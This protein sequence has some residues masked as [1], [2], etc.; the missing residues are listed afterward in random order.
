MNQVQLP[1]AAVIENPR[2]YPSGAIESLRRL[3]RS[4]AAPEPDPR[5]ENF[6]QIDGDEEVYYIYVSP[7]SGNVVLLAN[8][9]LRTQEECAAFEACLT[10]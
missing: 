2:E 9:S 4:G 3:L 5:R 10:P 1:E 7:I 6:Y 8:W